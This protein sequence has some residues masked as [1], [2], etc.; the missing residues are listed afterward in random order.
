MI[1]E[2]RMATS[3]SSPAMT[4]VNP[5]ATPAPGAHD[6]RPPLANIPS[7]PSIHPASYP[8]IWDLILVHVEDDISVSLALRDT[9]TTL[10]D[11]ISSRLYV[12]VLVRDE[13]KI[14]LYVPSSKGHS[15]IE[16]EQW[17]SAV[18]L[19]W[20]GG[21]LMRQ[22]CVERLKYCRL[23]QNEISGTRGNLDDYERALLGQGLSNV[24][25]LRLEG[26]NIH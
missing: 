12:D 3:P 5:T 14:E 8:H 1:Q 4:N 7:P 10:R 23:L 9:C 11:I 18:G 2:A 6:P 13:R 16:W 22:L 26:D 24:E 25:T 20:N 19:D 17:A 15:G 21:D